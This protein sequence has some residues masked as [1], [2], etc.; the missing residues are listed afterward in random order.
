MENYKRIFT[1]MARTFL[2]WNTYISVGDSIP[3]IELT[4]HLLMIYMCCEH[5]VFNVLSK[6]CFVTE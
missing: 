3:L 6:Y 1:L 2:W 4:A 5:C